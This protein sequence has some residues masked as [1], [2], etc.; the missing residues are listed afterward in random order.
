METKRR[1]SLGYGLLVPALAV[2][3]GCTGHV[4]TRSSGSAES[5]SSSSMTSG[6]EA[7]GERV[8]SNKAAL[9]SGSGATG[10]PAAPA[11]PASASSDAASSAASTQ[12]LSSGTPGA[13]GGD[14]DKGH[15]NDADGVDEDNA[16]GGHAKQ[17]K[18]AKDKRKKKGKAAAAEGEVDHDKGHGND[19]DGVDED[20]P[21]RS[22]QDG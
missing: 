1:K 5:E 20:N 12:S 7:R 6:S 8:G 4:T 3:G 11:A 10:T 15:G 19:A 16:A 13:A 17:G 18:K 21:G 22:K 2:L 9:R 14:H